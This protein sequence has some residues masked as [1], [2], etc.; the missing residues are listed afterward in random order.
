MKKWPTGARSWI[1]Y[2]VGNSAFTLVVMTAVFPL[3]FGNF[4]AKDLPAAQS[5]FWFGLAAS[6]SG[7]IVA[8]FSP[9][10][11]TLADLGG[12]RKR[13][14]G[15]FALSGSVATFLLAF[16]PA[17]AWSLA[18]IA[19]AVG[20][21][22]F[23]SA[24][25]FYDSLLCA[26]SSPENRHRVSAAGFSAGY[27]GSTLLLLACLLLI[28]RP[29]LIGLSDGTEATRLAFIL[30]ALWWALLTVPLLRHTPE[31]AHR[32]D[33]PG[34][35]HSLRKT[36]PALRQTILQ[37]WQI[38]P[39]VWFLTAYFFYIDGVNTIIRLAAK[40]ASDIG[41]SQMDLMG[42]IILVQVVGVLFALLFGWLGQRL[43]ARPLI[44]A[45]I[46]LY[47]GV[48]L[49]ASRLEADPWIIG[50]LSI[51]PVYVLGF[52]I[53]MAQGGVQSLSRSLFA[54]LVPPDKAAAFFG[55]FN[56]VGKTST[57]LGP[58]LVGTV[59]VLTG[60]SQSGFLALSLIFL[61]GLVLLFMAPLR[62]A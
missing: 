21:I 41:V 10:L 14:L 45:G 44:A 13:M 51:P 50:P 4:W 58:A 1:L 62:K 29:A 60:S 5:T 36:L 25:L 9:F 15:I 24:N 31:G 35:R 17:G 20:V 27:L 37:A 55:L 6:F 46:T 26:V 40:L 57:I 2:D 34:L 39:L 11:G 28:F 32:A 3:F 33:C 7:L 23:S 52:G 43:G 59:A 61:T 47:L 30:T 18:I 53:G 38:R 48:T 42:A 8:L 49:L 12:L 56:I 16:I 19:Y 54:N 22:C